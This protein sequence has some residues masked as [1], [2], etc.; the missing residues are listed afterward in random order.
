MFHG[1][2]APIFA[3]V[4]GASAS[5]M[6]KLAFDQSFHETV[7]YYLCFISSICPFTNYITTITSLLLMLALNGLMLSNLVTSIQCIGS[8]KATTVCS[9]TGFCVSSLYGRT[10]FNEQLSVY[11]GFGMTLICTGVYLLASDSHKSKYE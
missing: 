2:F 9:T 1:Y 4:L 7:Q 3:G 6:S 8:V 10:I 5:T 11:W